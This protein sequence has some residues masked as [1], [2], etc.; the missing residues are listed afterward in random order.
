MIL[1]R[2]PLGLVVSKVYRMLHPVLGNLHDQNPPDATCARGEIFHFLAT[3]CH[4][5]LI[6]L[7]YPSGRLMSKVYRMLQV[8][9]GISI[10]KNPPDATCARGDLI[11]SVAPHFRSF[12]YLSNFNGGFSAWLRRSRGM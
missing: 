2:Y 6:S 7:R 9:H 5:S 4:H 10:I 12:R 3:K 11:L 1:L 8:G